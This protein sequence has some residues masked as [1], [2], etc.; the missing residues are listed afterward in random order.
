MNSTIDVALRLRLDYQKRG[1]EAAE[2]DLKDLKDAADR[3]G[4]SRGGDELS[5]DLRSIGSSADDAKRKIGAIG[6]GLE[7]LKGDA[8]EAAAAIGTI[9]QEA[10]EAKAAIGRVDDGAFAGLKADAADAKAAITEVGQAAT[11]AEQKIRQM[12]GY[13]AMSVPG[14]RLIADGHWQT[15]THAPKT[16]AVT[17]AA[18]GAFDQLG[19]PIALGAG[20]AYMVGALPAG[21]AVAGGAAIRAAAGDEQR[22]DQLR[23]TGEYSEEEQRQI[24]N[25]LERA[26]ARRG[27]GAASAQ[28]VFGAL[29]AGGLSSGDA[30]AMVDN[31]IVFSTATQAGSTDAANLTIALRNN[32][33]IGAEG[34]MSAYDAIAYGGKKGQFEVP[35]M[36]RYFPELAALMSGVGERGSSGVNL[37]TAMLQA[38]RKNTGTSEAAA[39]NVKGMLGKFLSQDFAGKAEEYG[40]N[41]EKIIKSAQARGEQPVLAMLDAIR[42]KVGTDAFKLKQLMPD[43]ESGA[44]LVSA[45]A[46]LDEIRAMMQD[47]ENASGT[48]S[49]D[50]AIATDN[51]NS[52]GDRLSS[53]VGQNLKDLVSPILPLLTAASRAAAE[54]MERTRENQAKNPL[55]N[56][57]GSDV[58]EGLM[59]FWLSNSASSGPGQPTGWQRLLFGAGAEKG[60]NLRDH[61]GIDLRPTAENSMQ[62]YNDA[63]AAEGE[64][65]SA[66]AQSI[67]D[68]IRASLGFTVSPTIA[69][70]YVPP[71]GASAASGQQSSIQPMS[72][73]TTQYITSPNPQHAALR[74]NRLQ[75]RQIQQAQARSLYDTGRRLA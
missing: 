35:D 38:T 41:P 20:G 22:S 28:G 48:V 34:M 44:G 11:A 16:G 25:L 9:S 7:D 58:M 2:R 55:G 29:Q 50:Y 69:P 4:K 21:V 62:G 60:F 5:R 31:A 65:A 70:N 47:M 43:Q 27:V 53:N 12:R 36:A 23:V 24:D 54:Q 15:Q 61:L 67:A 33:G 45:V 37:L 10:T 42:G 8:R 59:K 26:G 74:A 18:E 57:P 17:K 64:K 66:E 40:L 14:G 56:V 72:N 71:S 73:R 52:Q 3:I 68:R 39:T 1:A 51:L 13:S 75:A 32:M 63:L 49:S 19:V 46:G 6:T 30:A